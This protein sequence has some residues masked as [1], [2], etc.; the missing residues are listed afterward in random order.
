MQAI[1]ATDD[2]STADALIRGVDISARIK[3][4]L[5]DI[6]FTRCHMQRCSQIPA[7]SM[8][9]LCT[10]CIAA[11][12]Y[13]AEWQIHVHVS[14]TNVGVCSEQSLD[15]VSVAAERSRMKRR[16]LIPASRMRASKDEQTT[17]NNEGARTRR[18]TCPRRW[19]RLCVEEVYRPHSHVL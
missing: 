7:T 4:R 15:N 19:H 16:S 13:M 5:N 17:G 11:A 2:L 10:S 12:L 8:M 1:S 6:Q 3:Q 9:M 18:H 14:G